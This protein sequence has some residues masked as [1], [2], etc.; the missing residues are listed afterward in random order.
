M[1]LLATATI[2]NSNNNGTTSPLPLLLLCVVCATT[3]GAITGSTVPPAWAIDEVMASTTVVAK[4]E[5]RIPVSYVKMLLE[6]ALGHISCQFQLFGYLRSRHSGDAA[7]GIKK[8]L[9]PDNVK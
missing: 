2:T 3:A 6:P 8:V 5:R 9:I 7:G 4:S 1:L